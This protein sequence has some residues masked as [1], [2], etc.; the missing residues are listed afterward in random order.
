[1]ASGSSHSKYDFTLKPSLR[2]Y[3]TELLEGKHL[4]ASTFWGFRG[5]YLTVGAFHK[6]PPEHGGHPL[7]ATDQ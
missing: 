7:T 3:F 6:G 2:D 4:A 5:T 1:M